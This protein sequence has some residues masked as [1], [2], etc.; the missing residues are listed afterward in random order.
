[1]VQLTKQDRL[2]LMM[3]IRGKNGVT[4]RY[5][6]PEDMKQIDKITSICYKA[7]HESWMTAQSEDIYNVLRNPSVS[8][9]DR[10]NAQNHKLFAEHPEWVWVIENE[11][12]IFGYVTFKI[13]AEKSLGIIDN[14][15][16]LPHFAGKGWGEVHVQACASVP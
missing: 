15:G 11:Q 7:I 9:Q 10:K 12:G 14:N 8:W 1:M 3:K 13:N 2:L 6:R 5:A 16:V 4:L